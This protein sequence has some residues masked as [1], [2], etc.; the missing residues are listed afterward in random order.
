MIFQRKQHGGSPSD[1]SFEILES[2]MKSRSILSSITVGEQQIFAGRTYLLEESDNAV[3]PTLSKISLMTATVSFS[4]EIVADPL[5]T[6]S[7][8]V[9]PVP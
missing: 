7:N 2:A 8:I 6:L 4:Q 3:I 1:R 5:E 9:K